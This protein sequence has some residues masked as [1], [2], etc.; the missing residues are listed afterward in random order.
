MIASENNEL[1]TCLTRE[2]VKKQEELTR[3]QTELSALGQS[4]VPVSAEPDT[5]VFTEESEVAI[6]TDVTVK[7]FRCKQLKAEIEVLAQNA[8]KFLPDD[9]DVRYS[10][11]RSDFQQLTAELRDCLVFNQE[12]ERELQNDIE[13]EK[14]TNQELEATVSAAERKLSETGHR[15]ESKKEAH[16]RLAERCKKLG[17]ANQD[18]LK[19][20]AK[21]I[22]KYYPLPDQESYKKVAKKVEGTADSKLSKLSDLQPLKTIVERLINASLDSP[23]DPYLEI[24]DR[25]WPP[26]TELL[27]QCDLA[28]RHPSDSK[29][30]KLMPF[31]L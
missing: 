16:K 3:L 23:N 21:F 19:H 1:L 18:K 13:G 30:I 2:N 26:Y 4:P 27:L 12:Q 8:P 6:E 11:L 7:R 14:R 15:Q 29:R 24:D 5:T 9:R 31:H 17:T 10:A 25:F 28:L 22:D 20:M